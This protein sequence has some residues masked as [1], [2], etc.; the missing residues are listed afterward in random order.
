M[1]I[2]ENNSLM[3]SQLLTQAQKCRQRYEQL[4]SSNESFKRQLA[5]ENLTRAVHFESIAHNL[6]KV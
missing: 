5:I 2:Q 1:S 6:L 3:K 4:S